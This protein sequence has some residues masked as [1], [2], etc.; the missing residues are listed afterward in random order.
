MRVSELVRRDGATRSVRSRDRC[1]SNRESPMA[2]K[3]T[4]GRVGEFCLF[5]V[6]ETRGIT[7][8]VLSLS[9]SLSFLSLYTLCKTALPAFNAFIK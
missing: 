3:T 9:L 4:V 5:A 6:T 8:V 1:V 7:T 2:R